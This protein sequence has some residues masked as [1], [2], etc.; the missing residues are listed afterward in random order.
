[1]LHA[2][3]GH[4]HHFIAEMT[5]HEMDRA[6]RLFPETLMRSDDRAWFARLIE[7]DEIEMAWD[8][9]THESA[10]TCSVEADDGG[11]GLKHML[12]S[13]FAGYCLARGTSFR[14]E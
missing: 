12:F 2:D 5:P 1:M 7:R 14:I 9:G 3:L 13:F 11:I 10:L 8:E 4:L 6:L